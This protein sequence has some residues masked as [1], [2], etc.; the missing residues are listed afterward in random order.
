MT[1]MARSSRAR[2]RGAD[3]VEALLETHPIEFLEAQAGEQKDPGIEFAI[4]APDC[5]FDFRTG[6]GVRIRDAPM[7][8]HRSA[9]P[10]RTYFACRVIA[11]CE[12]EVHRKRARFRKFVPTFA[13]E[14]GGE[15]P[16]VLEQLQHHRMNFAARVTARAVGAEFSLAPIIQN[17]FADDAAGAVA[18]AY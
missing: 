11:D 14:F 2:A 6:C 12:D 15:H 7:R 16:V 17:R 13:A 8:R 5:S 1:M 9:G 18:G 3:F 4:G 10:Y